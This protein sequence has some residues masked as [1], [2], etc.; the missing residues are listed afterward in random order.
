MHQRKGENNKKKHAM[1]LAVGL[2]S[3]LAVAAVAAPTIYGQFMVSLDKASDYPA[4]TPR[5]IIGNTPALFVPPIGT[6]L[7]D[8]AWAVESNSSRIGIRG[9]EELFNKDMSV[10]YQYETQADVDGDGPT[11][12]TRNAFL[13]LDTKVGKIFAG[14]YDSV[15]KL[16]DGDIDQF[17]NTA[18]DMRGTFLGQHRNANTLNW[19]SKDMSGMVFRVQLAPG[20]GD[21]AGT[22]PNTDDKDGLADTLG[23]S[24]TFKQDTLFAAFAFEQSYDEVDIVDPLAPPAVVTV[25]VD[26]QLIRGSAGLSLDGGIELGAIIELFELDPDLPGADKAD[27]RSFLVS[28]KIAANDRLAFKAQLGMLDSSDLDTEITT[29]SLGTDY[30]LG[31]QTTAYALVSL[32]D[33]EIEPAPLVK[34]DE[35]GNVISLGLK[36]KF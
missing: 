30:M 33:V 28:G 25:G 36:H 10:I 2:V 5:A 1:A 8:D 26:T 22:P 12:T 6:G 16:A 15:T 24:V 14:N 11:F 23:A 19:E 32:S 29:I 27:G 9:S 18:A 3:S 13:G 20:E 31:K 17:D 21:V 4:L 35:S 7:F 34:I